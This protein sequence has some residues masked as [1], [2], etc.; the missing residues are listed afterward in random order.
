MNHM[1]LDGLVQTTLIQIRDLYKVNIVKQI[2]EYTVVY[3]FDDNNTECYLSSKKID[4]LLCKKYI[5][6]YYNVNGLN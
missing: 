5:K 6:E 4:I 2:S 1:K 3:F